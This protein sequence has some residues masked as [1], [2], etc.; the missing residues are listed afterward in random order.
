MKDLNL[1]AFKK[2]AWH[3]KLMFWIYGIDASVSFKTMC[4][5]FWA[6][7][8]TILFLPI[9][10][11]S[12]YLGLMIGNLIDFCDEQSNKSSRKKRLEFV[13][14]AKQI[15]MAKDKKRAYLLVKSEFFEK[16]AWRLDHDV[17][18]GL[19]R[20][21][22]EYY[23]DKRKKEINFREK[24]LKTFDNKIV[25]IVSASISAIA[26]TGV[27][28]ILL[29]GIIKFIMFLCVNFESVVDVLLVLLLL[30]LSIVLGV[31]FTTYEKTI[32]KPF[33]FVWK[34]FVIVG[35]TIKAIYKNYCPIITWKD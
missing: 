11:I 18:T 23:E 10:L 21:F 28:A 2:N 24:A 1:F 7:L 26:L 14:K 33:K 34:G 22:V 31:T 15:Y 32:S 4:P 19:E 27:S 25:K 35:K 12:K 5:Y 3:S 13:I 30:L 20:L 17:R 16:N 9:V 8:I 29:F 6:L